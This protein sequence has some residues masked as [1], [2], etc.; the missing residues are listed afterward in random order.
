MPPNA[1]RPIKIGGKAWK[2][3]QSEAPAEESAT[4]KQKLPPKEKPKKKRTLADI[5]ATP[6]LRRAIATPADVGHTQLVPIEEEEEEEESEGESKSDDNDYDA[7]DVSDT[8]ND[9]GSEDDNDDNDDNDDKDNDDQPVTPPNSPTTTVEDVMDVPVKKPKTVSTRK[10]KQKQ[11]QKQ[12]K[13]PVNNTKLDIKVDRFWA[14]HGKE[15]CAT[16]EAL[17]SGPPFVKYL[18]QLLNDF[19]LA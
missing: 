2:K 17:G 5:Y 19:L 9:S 4:K 10:S 15:V 6:A 14:V 3:L 11:K 12:K 16:R 18:E 7:M 13:K 1:L 8:P